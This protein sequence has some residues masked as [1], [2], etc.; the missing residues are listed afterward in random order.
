MGV[1]PGDL[2]THI[3]RKGV[4][5]MV[6]YDCILSPPII[7]LYISRGWFIDRVK[8]RYLKCE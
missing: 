2:D 8:K 6:S 5:T 4:S 1:N 7:S 3:C